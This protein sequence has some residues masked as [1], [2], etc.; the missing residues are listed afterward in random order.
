MPDNDG[1]PHSQL[2]PV[3]VAEHYAPRRTPSS[4]R[5]GV[6]AGSA[7][8]TAVNEKGTPSTHLAWLLGVQIESAG[9]LGGLVHGVLAVADFVSGRRQRT[10]IGHTLLVRVVVS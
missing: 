8:G 1:V 9:P 4:G 7:A 3:G 2:A 6:I 10:S 5:V